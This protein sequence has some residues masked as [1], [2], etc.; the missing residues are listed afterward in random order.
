MAFLASDSLA[1]EA[2][3]NGRAKRF[4]LI[5]DDVVGEVSFRLQCGQAGIHYGWL[6]DDGINGNDGPD[7][8]GDLVAAEAVSTAQDR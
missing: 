1:V 4:A 2:C 6:G 3:E 8:L 5:G 7:G